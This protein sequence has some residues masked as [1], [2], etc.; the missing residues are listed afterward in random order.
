MYFKKVTVIM[1][2]HIL[3]KSQIIHPTYKVGVEIS[4]PSTPLR[5]PL[6]INLKYQIVYIEFNDLDLHTYIR[7][8]QYKI[9]YVMQSEGK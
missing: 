6:L 2:F 4:T 1:L 5:W 3:K 9:I 8:C 7:C